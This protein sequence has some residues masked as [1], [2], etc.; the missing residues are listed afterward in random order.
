[1]GI[2]TGHSYNNTQQF[3]YISSISP[4]TVEDVSQLPLSVVGPTLLVRQYCR[5]PIE[6]PTDRRIYFCLIN[7]YLLFSQN[8]ISVLT[9]F[10]TKLQNCKLKNLFLFEDERKSKIDNIILSES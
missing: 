8:N 6:L 1:V 7:E 4:T 3:F 10:V 2:L 5:S 9:K